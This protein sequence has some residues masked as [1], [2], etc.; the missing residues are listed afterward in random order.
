MITS[1]HTHHASCCSKKPCTQKTHHHHH[2]INITSHHSQLGTLTSPRRFSSRIPPPTDALDHRTRRPIPHFPLPLSF[3]VSF[4]RISV[5]P[6]AG[7]SSIVST[8]LLMFPRQLLI[9]RCALPLNPV[10]I[11][12]AACT[13]HVGR[14]VQM[15]PRVLLLALALAFPPVFKFSPASRGRCVIV[16]GAQPFAVLLAPSSFPS[17]PSFI[18]RL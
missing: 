8:T 15:I 18:F 2:F 13:P 5:K 7:S 6:S 10:N 1:I 17:L 14:P 12:M 9:S 11:S 4:S 16:S 3:P